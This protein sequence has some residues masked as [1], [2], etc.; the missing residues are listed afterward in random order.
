MDIKQLQAALGVQ[1]VDGIIGPVTAVALI[2]AAKAGRVTVASLPVTAPGKIPAADI[3]ASGLA[4]LDGVHRDLVAVIAA[5]SAACDTP[6]TVIEGLRTVARQ[7]ELV[8]RGASKT[9]RSR[10]LTGHAVDLWPLDP[11]T[12]KALPA[13]TPAAEARL[14]AD[15]RI[16]AAAVKVEA[17][18]RDVALEWGGDWASFPDGPHFQLSWAAYP[19]A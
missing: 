13:G 19:A 10:H 1:P 8:A 14:W 18:A 9:I 2:A 17:K 3:P 11:V 15:L 12:G 16:I 5:A 6:F 4:K 7:K